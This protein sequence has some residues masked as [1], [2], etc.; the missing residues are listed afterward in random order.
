MADGDIRRAMLRG[1]TRMTPV[2]KIVNMNAMVITETEAKAGRADE[3]FQQ[4]SSIT[5]LPVVSDR[6]TLIDVL[7]REPKKRKE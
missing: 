2:S 1:A 3:I 6:N 5:I 7:I 4:E